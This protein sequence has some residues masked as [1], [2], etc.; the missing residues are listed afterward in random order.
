M[1]MAY[2]CSG[3]LV[4]SPLTQSTALGFAG[5]TFMQVPALGAFPLVD[6]RFGYKSVAEEFQ[7]SPGLVQLERGAVDVKRVGAELVERVT[8]QFNCVLSRHATTGFRSVLHGRNKIRVEVD[9]PAHG[10]IKRN[11]YRKTGERSFA[12]GF[13][14]AGRFPPWPLFHP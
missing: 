6:D 1:Q 5:H 12:S 2:L 4:L 8:F 3:G 9:Q 7:D 11:R 10:G 13:R 14:H